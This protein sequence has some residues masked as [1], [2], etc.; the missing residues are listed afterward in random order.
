MLRH[1]PEPEPI[2]IVMNK[3][4]CM[5]EIDAQSGTS[6]ERMRRFFIKNQDKVLT[7]DSL[8]AND[9]GSRRTA[10]DSLSKLVDSGEVERIKKGEYRWKLK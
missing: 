4:T 3:K 5:F 2:K 9:G 6:I 8:L 10:H 7:F 1:A